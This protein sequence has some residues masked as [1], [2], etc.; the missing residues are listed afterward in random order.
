MAS[1]QEKKDQFINRA[2]Q[3]VAEIGYSMVD[4]RETGLLV[5][6]DAYYIDELLSGIEIIQSTYCGL[7]DDD[8]QSIID[9]LDYK[10]CLSDIPI[11]VELASLNGSLIIK[12]GQSIQGIQGEKGDTGNDGYTP[13]KGVDYF[14]GADGNDGANG[15][16]GYTPVKGVDYFDG[17]DG[18]DGNDGIDGEGL[19]GW[20][21]VLSTVT[22][23]DKRVHQIANWIST[24]TPTLPQPTTIGWYIGEVGYVE[25][26][27][28]AVDIRG[29]IGDKGDVGHQGIKGE[30]GY[31]IIDPVQAATTVELVA[32]YSALTLTA[33]ANGAFPSQDG[34]SF[35]VGERLLVK[36]QTTLT[37]NGLYEITDLGDGATPYILT[38][39]SDFNS[40]QLLR[41]FPQCFVEGGATFGNTNWTLFED[42]TTLTLDTS[43]IE[44]AK[45]QHPLQANSVPVPG[46]VTSSGPV[47]DEA[48]TVYDE[49][50]GLLIKQSETTINSVTKKLHTPTA[51][52]SK[53]SPTTEIDLSTA[54]AIKLIA[55]SIELLRVENDSSVG[56]T[57]NYAK[58][59]ANFIA[60]TPNSDFAINLNSTNESLGVFQSAPNNQTSLDIGGSKA[61]II[62]R[63][64]T[65]QRN[66]LTA[67]DG[68]QIYNVSTAKYEFRQN[69]AWDSIPTALGVSRASGTLSTWILDSG[70]IY[71]QDFVHNIG[72]LD[73]VESIRDNVTNEKVQ[74]QKVK[75][76]DINTTR[77]Y[78][79]G[80]TAVLR[81]TVI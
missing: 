58:A 57:L 30:S 18:A 65:S 81:I 7:L 35:S 42:R 22:N 49:V 67:A 55:D 8:T 36:D 11:N 31:G 70:D 32:T 25:D 6:N 46:N 63:L 13:V 47:V 39:T 38:R 14:D 27:N 21:P 44:F 24:G 19:D 60:R 64:T 26:I 16:D 3:K 68:M 12:T 4:Q 43:D 2:K 52:V 79:K 1:I 78:I 54:K 71:Y 20:T 28:D 50:T 69:G 62:P 9:Y 17:A 48:I 80:N 51:I 40:T 72:T 53:D 10:Y 74:V 76:Q 59:I 41:R 23:G 75:S 34:Y 29:S 33:N 45:Q 56:V 61:I 5:F 77:V 73:V 37:D 15:A 66:S